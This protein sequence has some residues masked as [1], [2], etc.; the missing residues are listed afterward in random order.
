ME[1]KLLLLEEFIE[2]LKS[3]LEDYGN[4]PVFISARDDIHA[5]T[6]ICKTYKVEMSAHNIKPEPCI[7]IT[8]YCFGDEENQ[9]SCRDCPDFI[10]D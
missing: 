7:L 5:M 10:D 3:D 4:I 1:N 9:E 2:I 8:D 6:P